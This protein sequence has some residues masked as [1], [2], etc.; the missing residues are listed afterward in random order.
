MCVKCVKNPSLTRDS[1]CADSGTHLANF[2]TCTGCD[3]ASNA[4]IIKVFFSRCIL[5]KQ[6]KKEQV[7]PFLGCFTAGSQTDAGRYQLY[8]NGSL[9]LFFHC[10]CFLLH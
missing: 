4:L 9:V 6:W 2:A 7:W 1:F 3:A 8:N 10:L 5:D